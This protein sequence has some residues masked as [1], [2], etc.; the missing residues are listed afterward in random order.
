MVGLFEKPSVERKQDEKKFLSGQ[1]IDAE[2]P[3]RVTAFSPPPAI[4]LPPSG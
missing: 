3:N 2:S 1:N 4:Q